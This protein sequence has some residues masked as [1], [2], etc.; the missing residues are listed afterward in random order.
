M[1]MTPSSTLDGRDAFIKSYRDY[2][3]L[4]IAVVFA[5]V[6]ILFILTGHAITI[7]SKDIGF[8]ETYE[9]L[10]NHLM[11]VSYEFK[12]E[13]WYNDY[14]IW[15]L[16]SPRVIGA[17]L[18]GFGLAVCGCVM[19]AVTRNPLADPY[20][21]GMS[22]GS[23]F[24]VS[25]GMVFGFSLG[26]SYGDVAMMF[27]AFI[28]GLIPAIF[29]IAVSNGKA[30]SP[31]TIV[32]GGVAIM[33]FFNS[34]S[35]LTMMYAPDSTI[36]KS[37][38][39]QLGTLERIDIT[40][41]PILGAGVALGSIVV[42]LFSRQLNLLNLGNGSASTLGLDVGTFRT[43]MIIITAVMIATIISFTGIIGFVGLVAPHIMRQVISSDNRFLIPCAGLLG[44]VFLLAC[45]T[46][47]R[48]PLLSVDL[49]VGVVMSFVGAPIFLYM[50]I[51]SR[52]SAI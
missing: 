21:T 49:P 4:K 22:S 9:Y 7:G 1:K 28:F 18:V 42:Y 35:T 50:I 26:T 15:E 6:I 43:I 38:L 3:F 23:V 45:D 48:S 10:W 36:M 17:I 31:A 41:L 37:Y 24:G 34:M 47:C 16:R 13:D 39:W 25:I 40:G 33:Y 44:A 14:I 20:T 46:L 8:F 27:N 5:L 52:R 2:L 19:Q 12:T 30:R 51:R 32:L 29:I 11:G